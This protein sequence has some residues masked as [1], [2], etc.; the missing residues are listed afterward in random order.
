M[1]LF[2]SVLFWLVLAVLGALLAQVLLQDPGYVLVRY[3]GS[4]YTT[5]VA[6]GLG[7]LLAAAFVAILLWTLLR[8][9]FRAWRQRRERQAR[10]RLVDGLDAYQRGEYVRA[11]RLLGEAADAGDAEALARAHAARAALARGDAEAAAGHAA[12]LGER[13]PGTRALVLAEDALARGAP[14]EA[15]A[16][17][18]LPAAQPLP[19]AGLRLR[20]QALALDG[21]AHEAYGLLGALRQQQAVPA[22]QWDAWQAQWAAQGLAEATDAN[23]LADRW[24]ALPAP[25]R[26]HPPVVAAYARRA[27][28]MGWHEAAT[29]SLEQALDAHW[30]EGL[31]ALYGEPALGRHE[32][33]LARLQQWLQQHPSSPALLLAAARAA[34]AQGQRPQA[35]AWLNRAIA[36]GA[37]APAWEALGD[38]AAAGGDEAR[39]RLAYGNALRGQRGEAP[40]PLPGRDLRQDIADAAAVEDRDDHGLPRLRG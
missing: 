7:L 35:E 3:R 38:A 29:R 22:A 17:L 31:A 16:A 21:R 18:D 25:L 2:R 33:R 28:G 10:A 32:H 4:D 30:D 5:T 11:E 1:S 24:D 9:P 26:T 39:A 6:A 34:A 23:A 15:L 40:L 37:G 36:Q 20:A 19:P 12:A 8:L 14:R 27:A 13:H